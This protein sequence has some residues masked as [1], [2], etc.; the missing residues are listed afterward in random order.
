MP[1]TPQRVSTN[2]PRQK[3]LR[4]QSVCSL[5]MR[6]AVRT[7]LSREGRCCEKREQT[8]TPTL[9]GG[10]GCGRRRQ[11][12]LVGRGR[13]VPRRPW[14][15]PLPKRDGSSFWQAYEMEKRKSVANPRRRRFWVRCLRDVFQT[16]STCCWHCHAI[17]SSVEPMK[18]CRQNATLLSHSSL[19]AAWPSQSI[20]MSPAPGPVSSRI[21]H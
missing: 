10:L 5:W 2:S 4:F 7:T 18:K 8:S 13:R 20:F 19:S 12:R 9:F 16:W 3:Q 14:Q 1:C 15:P 17:R 11:N 6:G 21:S